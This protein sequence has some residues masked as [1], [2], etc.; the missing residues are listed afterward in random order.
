M[1]AACKLYSIIAIFCIGKIPHSSAIFGILILVTGDEKFTLTANL[2]SC[3]LLWSVYGT[4]LPHSHSP[5]HRS[6]QKHSAL[7][8][9]NNAQN[10]KTYAISLGTQAAR[11][12]QP[13]CG[14]IP[15]ELDPTTCDNFKHMRQ[16]QQSKQDEGQEKSSRTGKVCRVTRPLDTLA[17]VKLIML[18]NRN[19]PSPNV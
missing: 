14:G 15:Q 3:Q 13:P 10:W 16:G 4:Q 8:A 17:K 6:S 12:V 11:Q 18:I 2:A 5:I 9:S 7:I 1:V 19:N